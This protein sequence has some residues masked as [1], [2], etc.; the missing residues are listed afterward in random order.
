MEEEFF[1]ES[2]ISD[3][4]SNL[5]PRISYGVNGNVSAIGNFEAYGIYGQT[6]DYAGTTGF[7]SGYENNGAFIGLMNSKLRWEQ[8]QT[9]EVGLDFSFFN[10]RLSFIADY[11]DRR[12]KDLLTSLALPGYTGYNS[13][14]TNLG[15]LHNYGF[16]LEIKA[17]ILQIC[18][19]LP[20]LSAFFPGHAAGPFSVS[21]AAL[22]SPCVG[23][24]AVMC[25]SSAPPSGSEDMV[26]KCKKTTAAG[27]SLHTTKNVK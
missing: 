2:P 21:P 9:F 17:N 20:G 8:S 19:P 22:P 23:P 10:N 5:K 3:Y 4:V 15:I 12:T 7:Q 16:K 11:Y 26:F 13:I 14:T 24:S 1:K 25:R 27:Q 18:L 6:K